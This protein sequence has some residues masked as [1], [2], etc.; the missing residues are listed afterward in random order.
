MYSIYHAFVARWDHSASSF[1][2]TSPPS[3]C[4]PP[5]PSSFHRWTRHFASFDTEGERGEEQ[6]SWKYSFPLSRAP[7]V[8]FFSK[9]LPSFPFLF[10]PPLSLPPVLLFLL[11]SL[12]FR[13]KSSFDGVA[14]GRMILRCF[15]GGTMKILID[16][17]CGS[18]RIVK[19]EREREIITMKDRSISYR[20][21]ISSIKEHLL[22]FDE[23]DPKSK[24]N[25]LE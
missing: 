11:S 21:K 5:F 3:L 15:E 23:T 1:S 9:S 25:C 13:S 2:P 17:D 24:T 4:P 20:I 7:R 19:R 22:N 12:P 18:G 16:G 8:F 14:R 6:P 10:P